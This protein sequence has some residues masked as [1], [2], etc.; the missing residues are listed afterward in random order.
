M[1]TSAIGTFALLQ[2]NTDYSLCLPDIKARPSTGTI[3]RTGLAPLAIQ[4]LRSIPPEVHSHCYKGPG[5][6]FGRAAW[7]RHNQTPYKVPQKPYL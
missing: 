4:T 6:V 7:S 3:I 5:S 2:I 1:T